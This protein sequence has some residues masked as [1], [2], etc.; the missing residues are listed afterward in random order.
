VQDAPTPS[1]NGVAGVV[2]AR[3]HALTARP[4][5]GERAAA[6]ARAFAGRAG[7][8]G[9]YAA[10]YLLAVDW[11]LAPPTHLVVADGGDADEGDR[12]LRRALAA[13]APR[14]VVQRVRAGA[15]GATLP[16]A[17]AAMARGA[18]AGIDGRARGYACIGASCSA[19]AAGEEAWAET[20]AALLRPGGIRVD[21]DV[22]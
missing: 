5:W 4:E 15:D 7:E 20:L 8:L 9:L 21:S 13:Y 12:M 2:A 1:P 17:V 14:R 19:P 6:L 16:P 10:A 22:S 18:S 3:L 11:V